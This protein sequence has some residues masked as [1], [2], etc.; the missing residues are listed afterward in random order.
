MPTL[1]F[2]YHCTSWTNASVAT[3]HLQPHCLHGN[4]QWPHLLCKYCLGKP[5]QLFQD[6]KHLW[7]KSIPTSACSLHCMA[8]NLDLGIETCLVDGMDA[9]IRTWLQF[10]FPFYHLLIISRRS[11]TIVKLVGS[12]AVSVLATLL[13]L[14]SYAKLQRCHHGLLLH[15]CTCRTTMGMTSH[16]IAVRWECSIPARKALSHIW[17][18]MDRYKYQAVY[19]ATFNTHSYSIH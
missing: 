11:I 14:L 2:C 16:Y 18:Y 10:V 19:H 4:S 5:H 9:Y 3:D 17:P 13:F 1:L 12:S 7:C 6:T 15:I 8:Q